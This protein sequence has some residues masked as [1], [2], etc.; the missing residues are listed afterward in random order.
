M[1]K[2]MRED[3]IAAPNIGNLSRMFSSKTIKFEKVQE[4]LD[5]LGYELEIKP[6]R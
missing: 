1:I 2:K 5:Y 4:I 6:K 3:N